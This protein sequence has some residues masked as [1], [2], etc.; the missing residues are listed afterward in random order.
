MKTLP[1]FPPIDFS[2]PSYK[3]SPEYQRMKQFLE[4]EIEF[5]QLEELMETFRSLVNACPTQVTFDG[6]PDP[7][8]IWPAGTLPYDVMRYLLSLPDYSPYESGLDLDRT[9]GYRGFYLV[10]EKGT[11]KILSSGWLGERDAKEA[12]GKA[13]EQ[14]RRY[15][16]IHTRACWKSLQERQAMIDED[17]RRWPNFCRKCHGAGVLVSHDDPSPAGVSLSPGSFIWEDPCTAC[18]EQGKCPRCGAQGFPGGD[19]EADTLTLGPCPSC[20]YTRKDAWCP[21]PAECTCDLMCDE[22]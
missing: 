4:E 21:P 18:V 16:R 19:D 13:H 22:D 3:Q 9:S 7:F 14:Y 8:W 5:R 6:I 11:G 10:R 2:H 15:R 1:T 12:C 20:G 17:T